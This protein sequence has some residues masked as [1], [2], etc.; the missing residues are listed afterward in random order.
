[1]KGVVF[2]GV[3]ARIKSSYRSEG[4]LVEVY[5][6][7]KKGGGAVRMWSRKVKRCKGN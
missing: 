1:M 5:A 4:G 7:K 6:S 3:R 2:G